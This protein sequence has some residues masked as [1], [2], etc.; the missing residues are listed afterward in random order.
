MIDDQVGGGEQSRASIDANITF[1]RDSLDSYSRHILT[2][3]TYATIRE[4]INEGV[5]GVSHLIDIGNGGVFDYDIKLIP[6]ILALDLFLDQID[7]TSRPSHIKFVTGSA[8]GLPILD[9][10][11]DGV[12]INML[13]H[14]LVGHTVDESIAN[15]RLA[16]SEAL[17][18]LKPGS[19][20]ILIE[21][22]VPRWFYLFERIVFRLAS[23]VIR[24]ITS[25]PITLQYS[26]TAVAQQMDALGAAVEITRIPKG[27]WVLQYGIKVPSFLTPVCPYRFVAYK[28]I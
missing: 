21:S 24:L 19:R 8:L 17:R 27:R 16:L 14:H 2:L 23:R 6:D 10:K 11:F 15:M 12:L 9:G 4:S 20:L 18:V 1:F 5:R 26:S 13:L 25:H 7:V 3:D 28:R 22:C